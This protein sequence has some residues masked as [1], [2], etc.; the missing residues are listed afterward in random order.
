MIE[1]IVVVIRRDKGT[2]SNLIEGQAIS[3]GYKY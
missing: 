3:C 1:I 2:Y